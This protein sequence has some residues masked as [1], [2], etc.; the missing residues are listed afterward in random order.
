[1]A[2]LETPFMSGCYFYFSLSVYQNILDQQLQIFNFISFLG[3]VLQCHNFGF[4]GYGSSINGPSQSLSNGE[5]GI[6]ADSLVHIA[7]QFG[8]FLSF[9]CIND[10]VLGL[11]KLPSATT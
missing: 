6:G 8:S 3:S 4:A 5:G 11:Y 9:A 7:I 1:M 10:S 2:P